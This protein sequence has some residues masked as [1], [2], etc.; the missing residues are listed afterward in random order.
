MVATMGPLE[1]HG[2]YRKG[3]QKFMATFMGLS[4][5]YGGHHKAVK[6]S[7]QPLRGPP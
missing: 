1:V 4:E 6:G 5:V 2:G 7:W 3:L